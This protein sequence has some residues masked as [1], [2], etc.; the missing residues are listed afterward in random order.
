MVEMNGK[1]IREELLNNL[2]DRIDSLP[3]QLGLCVIQVGEDPASKVYV[4]QKEKLALELGYKFVHKNFPEEVTQEEI[5]DYIDQVNKDD[6]IDGILVQMPLPKHLDETVIQNRIDSKKDVDGLTYV[7]GGKVVHNTSSLLPCTPKGII[8]MLDYFRIDI[9][10]KNAVVIGR[11]ILVGKPMAN[12]LLNRDAT[13]TVCHSK[14]D[15]IA[16]YTK[17][18]DIVI[19]AVGVAGFLTKDM[20]KEGAVVIDV[21]INRIDGKL[22]G[23]VDY[24]NVKDLCS[25]ITPVPGGVGPMTVYELMNNVYD[26][27]MLRVK[28]MNNDKKLT[29][30][31]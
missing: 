25:Y 31:S 14:T 9:K 20:V 7:N 5:L 18:A 16:Y 12:L 28:P 21:G 17:N 1:L 22:Y 27:H 23:D 10:G 19:V 8:D 30:T 6:S 13:V 15:N 26:A 29:K 11:S 3:T 2:K 24:N 4:G